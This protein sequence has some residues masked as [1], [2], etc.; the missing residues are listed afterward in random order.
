[1]ND[2]QLYIRLG[3]QHI[4]SLSSWDHILFLWALVVVFRFKQWRKLLLLVTLFTIAHTTALLLSVYGVLQV[5]ETLIEKLILG[6]ILVTALTNIFITR[7]NFLNQIHYYFSFF[8]GLIHG[9]GFATDFKMI[10][11]GQADKL[12]PLLEFAT[13]IETAQI[14]L[15]LFII[16]A[17]AL[18]T[19]VLKIK[20]REYILSVS[21]V[22]AGYV[23]C[24]LSGM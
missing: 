21:A 11:A 14:I 1:M 18:L 9:L 6:T 3:F 5:D 15:G 10:I 4:L 12:L 22:I 20:E 17:G 2:L 7:R 8:F 16:S 24:R 19:G 23:L 13:G